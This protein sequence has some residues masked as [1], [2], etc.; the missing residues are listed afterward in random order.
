MYI[1]RGEYVY[2][3]AAALRGLLAVMYSIHVY[4]IYDESDSASTVKCR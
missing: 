3:P 4:Y 1:R 2:T